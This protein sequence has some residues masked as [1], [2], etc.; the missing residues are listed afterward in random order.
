MLHNRLAHARL[1]SGRLEASKAGISH[2]STFAQQ[3]FTRV[4]CI[5]VPL[6]GVL[7]TLERQGVLTGRF[8]AQLLLRNDRSEIA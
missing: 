4:L 2:N 7:L 5:S 8:R 3:D 6:T 1:A